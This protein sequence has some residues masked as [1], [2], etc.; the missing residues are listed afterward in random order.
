MEETPLWALVSC[1]VALLVYV[2][3][4][5]IIIRRSREANKKIPSSDLE[6]QIT[7]SAVRSFYALVGSVVIIYLITLK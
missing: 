6:E 2:L 7:R 3:M 1:L 4:H 5:I